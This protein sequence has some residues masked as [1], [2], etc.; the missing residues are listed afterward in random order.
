M[1]TTRGFRGPSYTLLT[2]A[3]HFVSRLPALPGASVIKL[4]TPRLAPSRLAQYLIAFGAD[5]A[6]ESG[7]ARSV[8]WRVLA[9]YESFFFAL[10]AGASLAWDGMARLPLSPRSYAYIPAAMPFT[11][12]GDPG[13]RVLWIK[14]RY[15]PWPGLEDPVVTW[16][17]AD[18]VAA[19]ETPTP[20]LRRRELIDPRDS[21]YDFNMS[22]MSFDPGVGLPQVEI[23]D[24]EHGLYMTAGG[25][26]YTLERD[27]HPVSRDD[28]IYMAPYCPQGFTAAESGAEYL[29]YKDVHRDGF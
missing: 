7:A 29:L 3:N 4:V 22:L 20:G 16:G 27:E 14:R 9:G 18:E 13:A 15:Q 21:R 23:H 26:I 12:R 1:V 5:P 11:L 19:T 10:D 25:G 8:Q 2:P 17:S 6:T 24:E 28:F